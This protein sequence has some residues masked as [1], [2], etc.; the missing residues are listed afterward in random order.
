MKILMRQFTRVQ[1]KKA[2]ESYKEIFR[3]LHYRH[4][5]ARR[6]ENVPAAGAIL[7]KALGMPPSRFRTFAANGKFLTEELLGRVGKPSETERRSA[8]AKYLSTWRVLPMTW[9][10]GESPRF[11]AKN[12]FAQN[13]QFDECRRVFKSLMKFEAFAMAALGIGHPVIF[14]MMPLR[15]QGAN[16]EMLCDKLDLKDYT[17]PMFLD[18]SV[19]QEAFDSYCHA[20]ALDM[21]MHD[22]RN[23][24]KDAEK[25]GRNRDS[26]LETHLQILD[27]HATFEKG[28]F[29]GGKVA[30]YEARRG[31]PGLVKTAKAMKNAIS[32]YDQ[33]MVAA[34]KY[35]REYREIV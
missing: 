3:N 1:F 14:P 2:E 20:F 15:I 24:S 22:F 23:P 18:F 7:A 4:E 27:N 26:K 10:P 35:V 25:R 32:W 13:F 16:K 21:E 6:D 5:F 12:L 11:F 29:A 8:L 17:A 28:D 33:K 31:Q 9:S 34:M 30:Y 19:P